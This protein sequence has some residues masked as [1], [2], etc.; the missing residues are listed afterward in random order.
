MLIICIAL[1]LWPTTIGGRFGAV[2]VAGNSM[3]PTYDLGDAVITWRKSVSVG[4]T[5]LYRVPEGDP[6]EGNPVIHRVVAGDGTGWVTQGDAVGQPDL[7]NPSDHDVLGV[8]QFHIPMGGRVLALM[9]SWLVIAVLG[10][11]AVL[12]IVWPDADGEGR[13]QGRHRSQQALIGIRSLQIG[14]S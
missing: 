12:L 6:G 5:I 13:R 1:V 10:A 14:D 8:A 9:R 7:W 2:M 4:D 11:L 3:E